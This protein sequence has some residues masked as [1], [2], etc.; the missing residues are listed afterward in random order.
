M[1]PE[2]IQKKKQELLKEKQRIIDAI[3][4]DHSDAYKWM[5]KN[6][7]DLNN[8]SKYA[9]SISL[10]LMFVSTSLLTPPARIKVMDVVTKPLASQVRQLTIDDLH[11]LKEDEQLRLVWEN[12]GPIINEVAQ[13]YKVTTGLILATIMT[14][15]NGNSLAKRNEPRINDASY[16]LGQLLYGT[17]RGMGF[18]GRPEDLYNPEI[19][20]DLIGKYHRR[21]LDRYGDGLTQ[22]Q[23]AIAYNAGNP[24][25]R[26]Q[27][28]HVVR[29]DHWL[30]K[31]SSLGV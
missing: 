17:A 5:I 30:Y 23:L 9:K 25:S 12:Y 28:G 24:Y 13:K 27:P 14:E 2:E 15:S 4:T 18:D 16:G 3:K 26:P 1:S 8:L 20:I 7:I 21:T 11:P 29:F 19:N 6:G 10:A 31:F 22:Q